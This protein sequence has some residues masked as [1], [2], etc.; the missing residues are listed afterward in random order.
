MVGLIDCNNFF[1]SCERVYSPRLRAPRPVVV[2]SNNDG[3]AVAISNEAKALGIKRGDPFFKIEHLCRRHN[4][5]VVSGNHRMYGDLSARVMATIGELV[6][7]ISIYSIDEC[8]IDLGA[9][10]DSAQL[11]KLGRDIV[12]RVRRNTGIP[13]S[14]GIAPTM[15]LAKVAARFAKKYAGYR[16]VCI[17]DSEEKRRKALSLTALSDIWGIGRRLSRRLVPMG[18]N[19]A[20]QFADIASEEVGRT[21]NIN[22]ERTHSELNGIPSISIDS[23]N[24]PRRKQMC[25]TRSFGHSVTDFATLE[26]AMAAFACIIGRKLREQG[27]CAVVL[28]AFIQ[29]NSFRDDE[30]QYSNSCQ[31][32]L[33]EPTSDTMRLT[34]A[35][36]ACLRQIFRRGYA[37]KR[38]GIHVH[39]IVSEEAVQGSLFITQDERARRQRIMSVIDEINRRSRSH[40][41]VYVGSY[42]PLSGLVR[43]ERDN[44]SLTPPDIDIIRPF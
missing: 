30:P 36:H 16:S 40:D 28:G 14:L 25:S 38:A 35:A 10:S 1:V 3:C 23:E 22:L 15:T 31:I 21:F 5:A 24:E 27:S 37:Y 33:E 34:A 6:P 19:N 39:E 13:S 9:R 20:L 44:R 41:K 42:A 18:Y 7:E 32:R 11:E 26:S 2:L 29:T 8:F 17:I 4:V 12:C 43:R